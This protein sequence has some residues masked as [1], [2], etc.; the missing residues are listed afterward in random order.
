MTPTNVRQVLAQ[1]QHMVVVAR[2]PFH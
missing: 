1:S 2:T